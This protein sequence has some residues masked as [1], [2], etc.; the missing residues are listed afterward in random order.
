MLESFSSCSTEFQTCCQCRADLSG[1]AKTCVRWVEAEVYDTVM[2]TAYQ[3][4]LAEA[5]F[6]KL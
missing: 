2:K 6:L 1:V 5:M 4:L 3:Y